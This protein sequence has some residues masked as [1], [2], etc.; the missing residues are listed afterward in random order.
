MRA[1]A[2]IAL[3]EKTSNDLSV[4]WC[5]DLSS[6]FA[7][8]FCFALFLSGC[9]CQELL[10]KDSGWIE[11]DQAKFNAE[12]KQKQDAIKHQELQR[13]LQYQ[14]HLKQQQ[15]LQQPAV[16]RPNYSPYFGQ[17]AQPQVQPNHQVIQPQYQQQQQLK[18]QQQL[19]QA[20]DQNTHLQPP[21]QH[22]QFNEEIEAHS[23]AK[24]SNFASKALSAP[25]SVAGAIAGVTIGVPVHVTKS[26]NQHSKAM[27]QSMND[28]LDVDEKEID[29]AG[30]G[31]SAMCAYPFGFMSGMIHGTIKGVG[32]GIS[33][34]S[35][36]PFSKESFSIGESK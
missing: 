14:E 31:M 1:R 33:S 24:H 12:Q 35:K 34:G 9:F 6:C 8:S 11:G 18:H 26:I 32:R 3:A 22:M 20:P 23:K 25:K 19:Q 13:Q 28:G 30:R 29:L 2:I 7:L 16:Y 4:A 10:A 15:N 36:K 27:K 21:V 5:I 17:Y